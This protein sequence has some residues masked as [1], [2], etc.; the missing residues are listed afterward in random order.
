MNPGEVWWGQ[1][2]TSL[3][4]I[5][6]ICNCMRDSKSAFLQAPQHIPWA[7]EFYAAVDARRPAYS[8]ERRL[9]RVPWKDGKEPGALALEHCSSGI[10]AN[11][12][13]GQTYA[14]YLG[15]REDLEICDYY[16]W[17][18]GVRTKAD[19]EKWVSF[20]SD[21][22]RAS[23]KLRQPAVFIVEYA[24]E[25]THPAPAETALLTYTVAD[26]DCRVFALE[27]ANALKNTAQPIYQAELALCASG[28]DPE[29]CWALLSTGEKLLK[30]SVRTVT[31]VNQTGQT[32]DGAPFEKKSENQIES[33]LW[34]AALI[35]L[36]PILERFRLRMIEKYEGDLRAALPITNSN[37]ESITDP[38]DLE[39]GPISSLIPRIKHIKYEDAANIRLCRKIRNLV[40][41]NKTVPYQDVIEMYRLK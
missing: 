34:E 41:H 14:D 26:Y 27:L 28:T 6:S 31:T 15:G 20:L 22:A 33:A 2:G 35:Q 39:I 1:I 16:L 5:R 4:L 12:W 36:F 25:Y 7:Q 23:S 19:A 17:V 37:G 21:Y 8:G 38:Q 18:T 3:R 29:F 13:P 40:A 10:R 24:G 11:Y 30:D 32:S 9:V